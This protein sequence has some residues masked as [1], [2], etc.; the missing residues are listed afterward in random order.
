MCLYDPISCILRSQLMEIAEFF[1]QTFSLNKL[2]YSQKKKKKTGKLLSRNVLQIRI[3]SRRLKGL[4]KE[5]CP[6]ITGFN[7]SDFSKRVLIDYR[8][9]L[10]GHARRK[11]ICL[12]T[13]PWSRGKSDIIFALSLISLCNNKS[14]GIKSHLNP[15]SIPQY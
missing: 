7:R 8:I 15:Y 14:L 12:I 5:H 9:S 3:W 6:H 4:F 1:S 2:C 10:T 13:F 11:R